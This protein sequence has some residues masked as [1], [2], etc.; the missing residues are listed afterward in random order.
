MNSPKQI[1][2][3]KLIDPQGSIRISKVLVDKDFF[4]VTEPGIIPYL[5]GSATGFDKYYS[6]NAIRESN[7]SCLQNI[8]CVC[9]LWKFDT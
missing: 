3:K 7:A 1:F 6:G 2:R 5:Q 8:L 9:L 4:N